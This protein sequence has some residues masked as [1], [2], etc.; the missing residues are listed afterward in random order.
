MFFY[1]YLPA[2]T[3]LLIQ[4]AKRELFPSG[5]NPEDPSAYANFHA[6]A[7]NLRE[8]HIHSTRPTRAIGRNAKHTKMPTQKFRRAVFV[9]LS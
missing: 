3:S 7:A 6:F 4:L 1:L 2:Y 8:R 9:M 5:P